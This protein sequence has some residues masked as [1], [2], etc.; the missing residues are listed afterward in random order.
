MPFSSFS[1]NTKI[2][3]ADMNANFT[4]AVHKTDAQQI[5]N[6]T[7]IPSYI[8][9]APSIAGTATLDLS[10]YNWFTITMPAGAVTLAI[11]NATVGQPFVIEILQD[12]VGS[13]TVTW[14]TT[15]KWANGTTPVLTTTASKKDTF[16]FK[17]AS[18][19]NYEG[20]PVGYGL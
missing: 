12:G 4:N 6:K 15:I 5:S 7:T 16:Q 13:R 19:G 14:F 9:L 10:T 8:T 3:S 17:V 20:Y 18:A 2:A 1:P 11:S